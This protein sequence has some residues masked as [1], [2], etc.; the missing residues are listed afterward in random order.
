M[1]QESH[2]EEMGLEGQELIGLSSEAL[3]IWDEVRSAMSAAGDGGKKVT[4]T[5]GLAIAA[6]ASAFLAALLRD[7]AD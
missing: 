6:K 4:S 3:A 1:E 5:E 7:I 2:I